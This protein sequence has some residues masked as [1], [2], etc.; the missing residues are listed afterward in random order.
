MKGKWRFLQDNDPKHKAA[1]TMQLLREKLGDR[2]IAHPANSPDL[3]IM[4]DLWS[5]FNRKVQA[6]KIT[7]MQGLKRTLTRE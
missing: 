3:N 4:E 1:A 2:I 7:T 5:Y 6:A